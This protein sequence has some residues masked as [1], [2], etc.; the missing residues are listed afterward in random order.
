MAHTKSCSGST[1]INGWFL[2]SSA[3]SYDVTLFV[4]GQPINTPVTLNPDNPSGTGT[5][6]AAIESLFNTNRTGNTT[7]TVS[8]SQVGS[9]LVLTINNIVLLTAEA[10]TITL[11]IVRNS[12][13]CFVF[14]SFAGFLTCNIIPDPK[15]K[16]TRLG[17][18]AMQRCPDEIIF[19]ADTSPQRIS[20]CNQVYYFYTTDENGFLHYIKTSS[21]VSLRGTRNWWAKYIN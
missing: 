13:L 16:K 3:C 18:F 20:Y 12:T 10:T 19:K 14:S 21:N 2:G 17:A 15:N 7:G 11:I 4:A 5:S 9:N 1:Q 8:A 6:I